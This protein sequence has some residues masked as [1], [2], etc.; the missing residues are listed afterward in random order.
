MKK[1]LIASGVIIIVLLSA[2][3]L[4][5]PNIVRFKNTTKI[6]VTRPG[7]CRML[8]SKDEVAKWWP[9]NISKDS[10]YI[11]D[12]KYTFNKNS[13]SVLPVIVSEKELQLHTSFLIIELDKENL[14]IEWVGAMVTSYNPVKRFFAYMKAKKLMK[15]WVQF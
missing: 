15:T 4:Y 10:F 7:L 8:T 1:W 13:L 9:G 2:I 6:K 3:Y 12:L 14:Q 11:N 5:I